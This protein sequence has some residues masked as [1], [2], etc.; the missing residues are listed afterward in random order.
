MTKKRFLIVIGLMVSLSALPGCSQNPAGGTQNR[1]E[2]PQNCA[3]LD[4]LIDTTYGFKPSKLTSAERTAKSAQMDAVWN[5]VKADQKSLVPCLRAA[6]SSRKADPFFRFDASSLLYSL[7]QSD[8]TKKIVIQSSAD[9]DFADIDTRY[10]MPNIAKFGYDGLDTSAAAETWLRYPDP[11][12]YLPQHGAVKID[13]ETGALIAYGS[14]D[15]AIAT[16]ALAKIAGNADHPGR[17]TAVRLLMQ[18]ATP[19]SFTELK[20][21]DAKGLSPRTAAD[22]KALLTKPVL[23]AKREGPPKITRQKYLDAFQQF[24][25]GKPDLFVE[26]T[27]D[28]PDG[29]RDVLAVMKE[30]D[31]PIIRKVRRFM[32]LSANPHSAEWYE[33]FTKILMAMVWKPDL[34]PLATE[35]RFEGKGK[36]DG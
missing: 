18:Q 16:P 34:G 14:M 31:I 10:W 4:K 27:S 3:E 6:I 25:A 22:L 13:K 32:M 24:T 1:T 29:E 17:E 19:E 5:K 7:D 23:L 35:A 36:L 28:S 20:K 12:Y 30:E 9:V 33:S 21:V 15:E 8:E 26:L 2:V 11:G